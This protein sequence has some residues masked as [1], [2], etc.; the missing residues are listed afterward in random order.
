MKIDW[1]AILIVFIL[2]G[3]L[4]IKTKN[5]DIMFTGFFMFFAVSMILGLTM[6]FSLAYLEYPQ[7]AYETKNSLEQI[8]V[9]TEYDKGRYND[10]CKSLNAYYHTK[11][12]LEKGGISFT[13]CGIILYI[14][15]LFPEKKKS[16]S[17]P[18]LA[19]P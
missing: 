5:T 6:L 11:K 14:I 16:E 15:C 3:L 9:I 7:N 4:K 12:I 17:V 10:A 13:I 1:R 19:N 2:V 8:H 18:S